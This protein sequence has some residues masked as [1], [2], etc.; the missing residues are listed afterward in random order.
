[1]R[2]ILACFIFI[3]ALSPAVELE[4]VNPIE[5]FTINLQH[6]VGFFDFYYQIEQDKVFLKLT[7]LIRLSYFKAVCLKVLARMILV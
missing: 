3:S 2:M 1:M 6:R 4:D 7:S 5:K